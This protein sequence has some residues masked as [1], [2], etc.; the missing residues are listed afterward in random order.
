MAFL[1][2]ATP[3]MQLDLTEKLVQDILAQFNGH[4]QRYNVMVPCCMT[5]ADNEADLFGIRKSDFSRV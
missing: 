5:Q 4:A 2:R 1:K 3:K